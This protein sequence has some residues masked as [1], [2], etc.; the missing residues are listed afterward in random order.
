[1][2]HIVELLVATWPVWDVGLAVVVYPALMKN[3]YEWWATPV[4]LIFTMF[5]F[6]SIVV[7]LVGGFLYLRSQT[8]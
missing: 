3:Q 7:W 4:G 8:G 5:A 2:K 1:M 6:G